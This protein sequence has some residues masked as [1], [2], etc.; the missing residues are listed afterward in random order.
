M[1]MFFCEFKIRK[2]GIRAFT[3]YFLV[4]RALPQII[5]RAYHIL[6]QMWRRCGWTHSNPTKSWQAVMRMQ[7]H[8]VEGFFSSWGS[9]F[10]SFSKLFKGG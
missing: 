7:T 3:W 6:S 1:A 10:C 5:L 2:K 8:G 9:T 4:F